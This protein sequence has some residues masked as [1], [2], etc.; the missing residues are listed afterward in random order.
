MKTPLNMNFVNTSFGN[1][2]SKV[3]YCVYCRIYP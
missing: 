1:Q 3:D 2:F